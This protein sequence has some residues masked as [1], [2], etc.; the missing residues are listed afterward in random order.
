MLHTQIEFSLCRFKDFRAPRSWVTSKT[1]RLNNYFFAEYD[2]CAM[3][4]ALV[5][6]AH[7]ERQFPKVNLSSADSNHKT[8]VWHL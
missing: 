8:H 4:F 6:S 1:V 5:K 7:M 2:M 3:L